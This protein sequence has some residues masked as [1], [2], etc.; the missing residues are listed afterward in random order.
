MKFRRQRRDELSINLTPLI[1]VVFLLLIFFMVSTSFTT[2]T[3]LAVNLP[4]AEGVASREVSQL[5]LTIDEAGV[6]RLND[7][8]VPSDSEGLRSALRAAAGDQRDL[9]MTIAADSATAHQYV[10]TALDVASKLGFKQLTIATQT[11]AATDQA[12]GN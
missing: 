6:F 2:R 10:V 5:E 7:E 8:V 12:R 11:P 1:D 9:P 4:E 3:Q